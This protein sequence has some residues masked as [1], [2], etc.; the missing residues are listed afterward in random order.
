MLEPLFLLLQVAQN[1]QDAPIWWSSP[2]ISAL[3]TL[4]GALVGGLTT[5]FVSFTSIRSARK[6]ELLL[7][8]RSEYLE[9]LDIVHR[10]TNELR[11]F[12]AGMGR[13]SEAERMAESG[14]LGPGGNFEE[15][16]SLLV[17]AIERFHDERD[18]L[19]RATLRLAVFGSGAA[20]R[21][22]I[23]Y[24]DVIDTYFTKLASAE[25]EGPV[26]GFK[27]L[28]EA[29]FSAEVAKGRFV[30]EARKDLGQGRVKISS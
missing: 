22:L 30:S 20:V 29:L 17:G 16:M 6:Q 8:K 13:A 14:E 7:R 18:Q 28:N 1:S 19:D 4:S 11:S 3:A 9:T 25:I 12:K 5:W 2:L 26:F 23:N 15:E 21:E 24:A 10:V 27:E